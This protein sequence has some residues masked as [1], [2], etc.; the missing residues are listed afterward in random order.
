[1]NQDIVAFVA[2]T[3]ELPEELIKI[4]ISGVDWK[5][6]ALTCKFLLDLYKNSPRN[7]YVLYNSQNDL[8][9][10]DDSIKALCLHMK[11]DSPVCFNYIST[12]EFLN[13]DSYVACLTEEF[14]NSYAVLCLNETLFVPKRLNPKSIRS[15]IIGSS[16][17][18]KFVPDVSFFQKF[19]NLESVLHKGIDFKVDVTPIF[20]KLPL[21]FISFNQCDLEACTASTMFDN[22]TTIQHIQL[23]SCKCPKNTKL[24]LSE[25]L[26]MFEMNQCSFF[27]YL[28]V[29]R[30]KKLKSLILL[31]GGYPLYL[32]AQTGFEYL[33]NLEIDSCLQ[34]E[35][36]TFG[37][38]ENLGSLKKLTLHRSSTFQMPIHNRFMVHD[39]KKRHLKFSNSPNFQVLRIVDPSFEPGNI[40]SC[41]LAKGDGEV[42]VML[43]LKNRLTDHKIFKRDPRNSNPILIEF[44][45][46]KE[47][48]ET[49]AEKPKSAKKH[50]SV[51]NCV[52][53]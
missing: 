2:H 41:E 50:K 44:E 16:S 48:E 3:S 49:I 1:M 28:D 38:F 37:H 5:T 33:E 42:S 39:F 15:I 34:F 4:I 18:E 17:K 51:E 26:N 8:S 53:S 47:I 20:S 9:L 25:N 13:N 24:R 11:Q 35:L 40:L 52:I 22:C 19:E 23:I 30:P 6:L 21:R 12:C 14:I 46:K 29:S 10:C 31:I 7:V 43:I 36:G 27:K 45:I 32:I